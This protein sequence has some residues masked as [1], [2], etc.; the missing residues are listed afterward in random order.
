M[1]P[2]MRSLM[3]FRHVRVFELARLLRV[4]DG[5]MSNRLNGRIP[6]APHE[7]NRLTEFFGVDGD[8]LFHEFR[9]PVARRE[10]AMLAPAMEAL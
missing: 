4:S 2:N 9:P 3:T 8:W 10:T 5:A 7:R 1:F 6:F